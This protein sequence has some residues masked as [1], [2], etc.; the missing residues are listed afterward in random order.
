MHGQ[1]DKQ[2]TCN[3][4]SC[5]EAGTQAII[6]QGFNGFLRINIPQAPTNDAYAFWFKCDFNRHTE[7]VLCDDI[8]QVD[9]FDCPDTDTVEFHR[10]TARKSA[11]RRVEIKHVALTVSLGKQLGLLKAFM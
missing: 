2:L 9:T 6:N 10:C 7:G 5:L 4:T 8:F 1:I 3:E 11:N